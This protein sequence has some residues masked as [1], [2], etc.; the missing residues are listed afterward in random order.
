[1]RPGYESPSTVHAEPPTAYGGR[2]MA[3]RF[4]YSRWDGTQ[5]GFEL[6]A[7]ALF[8]ELTDELLVPRRRQRRAAADDAGGPARPQRR[9]LQGLRELLEQLRQ[10]RQERLDRYDLG[11]VYDEIARSSTTSSTR[12]A[13]PSTTPP[14][15]RQTPSAPA[16]SAG[17]RRADAAAD[18]RNVRLDLL[19][20]D[21]A[22]KVRELQ[23]Y[24][25]ESAEAEQRFEQLMDSSASSSCSRWSTR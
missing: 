13:T 20:D 19:P 6:D 11:G 21:L 16:T 17:R 24:D 22:G 1:M 10:E 2:R 15:R 4:T 3:A 5:Q 7:D 25:F 18:D 9:A 14:R 12:S 23:H 8:D